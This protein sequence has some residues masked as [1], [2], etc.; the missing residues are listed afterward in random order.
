MTGI[1]DHHVHMDV[2]NCN[3]Y[4]AMA[5]AGVTTMLIP[6]SATGERKFCVHSYREQFDRLA[7]FEP[8]R[9]S[10][11]GV[12]LLLGLAVNAADVGDEQAA[13]AALHEI[14]TRLGLAHVVAVG[15]LTLRNFTDVEVVLLR[16]Q[17]ELASRHGC[18]IVV[19]APIAMPDFL[20]LLSVLEQALADGLARPSRVCLIDLNKEKL[21]AALPLGLG[22]YGLPVSPKT[23]GLFCL[24]E[25]L[26]CS[27]VLDIIDAFGAENLMLNSGLHVGFADP[28]G[29]PKTLLRLRL[30]GVNQRVLN[31]LARETAE[32]FFAKHAA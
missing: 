2:R 17:M 14:E 18:V 5:L 9:A 1:F 26:D 7:N 13:L 29:L 3:D 24:R 15:E 27:Q 16:R 11:F 10:A 30:H 8:K 32:A 20:R 19:E 31:Q 25:K 21:K 6:T 23:D 4:E 12:R 28:L 22:A